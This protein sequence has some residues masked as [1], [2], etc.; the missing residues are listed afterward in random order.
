MVGEEISRGWK[1]VGDFSF[2]YFATR[3]GGEQRA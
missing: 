2:G 1:R 3:G